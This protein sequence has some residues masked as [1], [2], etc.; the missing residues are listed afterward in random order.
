MFVLKL[1]CYATVLFYIILIKRK[2]THSVV[3]TLK[4]K[5]KICISS[6]SFNFPLNL[7]NKMLK[8]N[9]NR[10]IYFIKMKWFSINSFW[11][12]WCLLSIGKVLVHCIMGMSRSATLVLAYLM[13][14][15]RLTLRSAIQTVVLQRAIYPNRNF[16]S[17][18][19]ELDIQLQRKRMLCPILW[20]KNTNIMST[21]MHMHSFYITK[22]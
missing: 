14:R 13:L 7:I 12:L 16:L 20:Q 2:E 22:R 18:L 8:M 5:K 4:K 1:L 6:L 3:Y 15:Q 17:L 9:Y 21:Q 19:L 11:Q 10:D